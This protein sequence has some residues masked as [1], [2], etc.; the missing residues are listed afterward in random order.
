VDGYSSRISADTRSLLTRIKIDNENYELIPGSLLEVSVKFNERSSLSIPLDLDKKP[1]EN[2]FVYK[3]KT[4]MGV[5]E[6]Y[7]NFEMGKVIKG[8]RDVDCYLKR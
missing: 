4:F 1:G 3:V 5:N 2:T 6:I 7:V 8:D